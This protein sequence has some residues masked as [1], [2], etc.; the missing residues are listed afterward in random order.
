MIWLSANLD[1]RSG[2]SSVL[3]VV[4]FY[5]KKK[6]HN[7]MQCVYMNDYFQ[8]PV[9]KV[10]LGMSL[11][12]IPHHKMNVWWREWYLYPLWAGL[13]D[14]YINVSVGIPS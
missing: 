11:K 12:V 10:Y 7:W 13:L 4:V 3:F 2:L 9:K 8:N 5:L 1:P 14:I 6:K